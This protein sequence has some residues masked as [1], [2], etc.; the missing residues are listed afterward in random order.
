MKG[1]NATFFA[2]AMQYHAGRPVHSILGAPLLDEA[3]PTVRN[4]L[5]SADQE[6]QLLLAS[7]ADSAPP[8]ED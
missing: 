5:R 7:G 6:I 8:W 3:E 1:M 4:W 2:A